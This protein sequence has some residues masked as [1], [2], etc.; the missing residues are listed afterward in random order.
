MLMFTPPSLYSVGDTI[1]MECKVT[2]TQPITYSIL[3]DDTVISTNN[4]FFI[5]NNISRNDHGSYACEAE[6]VSGKKKSKHV[7]VNVQCK[8]FFYAFSLY[9]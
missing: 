5:L 3:R 1:V 9:I 6:N 2:G 7:E 4:N 8:S